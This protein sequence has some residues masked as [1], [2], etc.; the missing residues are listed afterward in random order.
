MS[1]AAGT[2]ASPTLFTFTSLEGN[3][4]YSFAFLENDSLLF[5]FSPTDPE[6]VGMSKPIEFKRAN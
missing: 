4:I 5:Y 2:Q 1:N 6:Q 3:S